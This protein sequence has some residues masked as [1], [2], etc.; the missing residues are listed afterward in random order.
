MRFISVSIVRH[1]RLTLSAWAAI[2]TNMD[3]LN[4]NK[5]FRVVRY[6]M[7]P[8]KSQYIKL[9]DTAYA[10]RYV[11]NFMVDK[12][13]GDYQY[14][15]DCNF[16][17]MS[18]FNKSRQVGISKTFSYLRACRSHHWLT[19]ISS[20]IVSMSLKPIE[21]AYKNFFK[22]PKNKGLPRF[23]SKHNTKPSMPIDSQCANIQNNYLQIA[24]IGRVRL[25][26]SEVPRHASGKFKHGTIKKECGKWYA[27]LAYE[28]DIARPALPVPQV[29]GI[30]RNVCANGFALSDGTIYKLPEALARLDAKIKKHDRKMRSNGKRTKG[31][32]RWNK[33]KEWRAKA[34]QKLV[35]A[36]DTAIHQ[37]SYAIA[38]KYDIAVL[39]DLHLASMTKSAKGTIEEPG[40]NVKAKSG[41]NREMLAGCSGKLEQ[42]LAYKM[43]VEKVPAAYTSQTCNACG[44]VDKANRRD[45][46]FKCVHCGHTDDADI[47]AARN[48]KQAFLAEVSSSGG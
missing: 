29:V 41:L 34:Y 13:R 26:C 14:S 19:Y 2:I 43:Q 47:N 18:K 44:V 27:Y 48:I 33:Y 46:L 8:T 42:A 5:E 31:S 35:H 6:L 11:W 25:Q 28:V 10:C 21:T 22:D 32:R 30:D 7:R 17:Y 40:K 38:N 1:A 24:K 37:I 36:R 9:D 23:K 39:E 3:M 45:R 20:R 15:G 12:L 16:Y 4:T